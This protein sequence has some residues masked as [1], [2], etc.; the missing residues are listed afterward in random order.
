MYTDFA[1]KMA[2]VITE[3]S[4][5][6][7]PGEYVIIMGNT[8]SAPLIEELFEAVLR[9]GGYPHPVVGLPGLQELFMVQASDQQLQFVDP[10]TTLIYEKADVIL[11]IE[12]PVNTKA[13]SDID[14]ARPAL[15]QQANAHLFRTF[16]QRIGDGSIRWTLM[17]WPTHAAAMQTEMGIHSYREFLY[18]ACGFHHD[19]PIAYWQQMRDRQLRLTDYLA[20]KSHAEVKGPGVDLSFD[21]G[22]R[23]WVSAHGNLNFPDG[24]FFTGPLEDSVNGT[25]AFNMSSFYQGREVRGVKFTYLN[26]VIVEASAEKGEDFLMSQLEM[27]EGARRLGEF[28]IGTNFGVTRVTGST[29]L[30]EKIGGTIHMA[31]GNSIPQTKG[32]NQSRI[33]WDMVHDMKN[34][35]EITID[36]K[37]FYRSGEFMV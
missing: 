21:F 12:A 36:G 34:G 11:Q 5:P 25:V 27:D 33:H 9:R 24:E 19:D 3:Y 18:K 4:S 37:L 32:V 16:L 30:D 10:I 23:L 26:G 2:K 1:P 7:Q 31:I 29:L 17:P 22:G 6:I 15:A 14:P 28:A 35:G 8:E 13:M 20:D